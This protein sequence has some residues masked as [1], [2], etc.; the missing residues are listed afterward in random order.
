MRLQIS[1]DLAPLLNNMTMLVRM[2]IDQFFPLLVGLYFISGITN[3]VRLSSSRRVM[4]HAARLPLIYRPLTSF[5]T[6]RFKKLYMS[7]SSWGPNIQLVLLKSMDSLLGRLFSYVNRRLQEIFALGPLCRCSLDGVS[8]AVNAMY[9]Y[10][11][12]VWSTVW[13]FTQPCTPHFTRSFFYK[14]EGID[15]CGPK[16][17]ALIGLNQ[18]P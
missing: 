14:G 13:I 16:S 10:S 4:L 12:G 15:E 1:Q 6:T 5:G 8:R 7:D 17:R 18:Q 9:K 2:I 3:G 11:Y